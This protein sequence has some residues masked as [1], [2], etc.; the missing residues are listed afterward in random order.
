MLLALGLL[1]SNAYGG[2]VTHYAVQAAPIV[3]G[4]GYNDIRS[5]GSSAG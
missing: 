5:G 1:F 2:S 3:F 4:A